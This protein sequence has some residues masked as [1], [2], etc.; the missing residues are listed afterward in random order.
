MLLEPFYEQLPLGLLWLVMIF[1][2]FGMVMIALFRGLSTSLIGE[3]TTCHMLG[4]LAADFVRGCFRLPFIA[5]GWMLRMLWHART[6]R[7][8]RGGATSLTS[9]SQAVDMGTMRWRAPVP[10]HGQPW[11]HGCPHRAAF[12]HMPTACHYGYKKDRPQQPNALARSTTD[13]CPTRRPGQAA[14]GSYLN[15]KRLRRAVT[16]LGAVQ[17]GGDSQ[18]STSA[19]TRLST[20]GSMAIDR[21]HSRVVSPG[22]LFVASRPIL[23]PRPLTG[24]AKSR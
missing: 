1:L 8:K 24:E 7:P 16:A 10:Q 19:A 15:R 3:R 23:P 11:V 4:E 17:R 20:A 9:S 5:I 22:H 12:A 14:P 6:H 21:P 13:R 18:P 2:G